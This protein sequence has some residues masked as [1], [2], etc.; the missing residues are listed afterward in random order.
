[1][2]KTI[3]AQWK[4]IC[5][6]ATILIVAFLLFQWKSAEGELKVTKSDNVAVV[7]KKDSVIVNNV[8]QVKQMETINKEAVETIA[9]QKTV[10]VVKEASQQKVIAIGKKIDKIKTD[11]IVNEISK[12]ETTEYISKEGVA[13]LLQLANELDPMLDI[14]QTDTT[15]PKNGV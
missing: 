15:Q 4:L 7:A 5:A 1:M 13:V 12:V 3:L 14:E 11:I 9:V 10:E 6:V 2:F 8:A